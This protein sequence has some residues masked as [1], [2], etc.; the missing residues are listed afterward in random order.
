MTF[1]RGKHELCGLEWECDFFQWILSLFLVSIFHFPTLVSEHPMPWEKENGLLMMVMVINIVHQENSSHNFNKFFVWQVD[2]WSCGIILYALLC[3]TLPFD[4]EHVPTLFRKIKCKF[5]CTLSYHSP[6]LLK[7][8]G[9]LSNFS[10][11]YWVFLFLPLA[12]DAV[13]CNY[14]Y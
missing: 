1:V 6:I 12:N 11:F 7:K 10:D 14:H 5:F 8:Y 3:G 4:D 2:V 13:Y 9:L